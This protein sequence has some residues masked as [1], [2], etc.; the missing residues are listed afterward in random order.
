MQHVINSSI[1]RYV[2]GAE[3]YQVKTSQ[4]FTGTY[5][6]IGSE[7]RYWDAT[8]ARWIRSAASAGMLRRGIAPAN[9]TINKLF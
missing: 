1:A 7:A 3:V 6:V 8:G 5:L 4:G 9:T 2:P